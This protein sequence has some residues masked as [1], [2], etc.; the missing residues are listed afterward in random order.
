MID[1][2]ISMI[3]KLSTQYKQFKPFKPIAFRV[4]DDI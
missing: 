2:L 3:G 4:K 1:K